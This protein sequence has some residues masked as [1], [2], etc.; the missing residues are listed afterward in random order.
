MT[1]II[2]ECTD[3]YQKPAIVSKWT[4]EL[5]AKISLLWET[6]SATEI[7]SILLKQDGVT[8]SR[9]ALLGT[10]HRLNLGVSD[11]RVL[12]SLTRD[13]PGYGEAKKTPTTTV[14][15]NSVNAAR[16]RIMPLPFIVSAAPADAS[17]QHIAFADLTKLT[18][19]WPFGSGNPSEFT[20]CGD[21]PVEDK[22]YCLVH[23]RISY[24]EPGRRTGRGIA[25]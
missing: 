11:K 12:H 24:V 17:L 16:K 25:A 2:S 13:H 4:D 18:C 21:R 7:S 5:T 1:D 3:L 9:N 8:V 20:F 19:K 15:I 10:L 14:N 6:K 23:C 22:P